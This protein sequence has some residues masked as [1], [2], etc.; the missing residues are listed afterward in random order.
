MNRCSFQAGL[1]LLLLLLTVGGKS[2]VAQNAT[3]EPLFRKLPTIGEVFDARKNAALA[4]NPPGTAG[5]TTR[6]VLE[7]GT[8]LSDS[9]AALT[10]EP[11]FFERWFVKNL[12]KRCRGVE[13]VDL[14]DD[15][16][17]RRSGE[18]VSI[19][20]SRALEIKGPKE[21]GE[22]A[23]ALVESM[24]DAKNG[25]VEVEIRFVV[26]SDDDEK[27]RTDTQVS[28]ASADEIKKL[29]LDLELR[30]AEA[31]SAPRITAYLGQR[32]V[33]AMTK[34][35]AY[36][37]D[38]DLKTAADTVIADPII[39]VIEDGL[40]INVSVIRLPGDE[41]IAVDAA[42]SMS[43]LKLPMETFETTV[44][45]G[46]PKVELQLPE[47]SYKTWKSD[48]IV[49]DPKSAGF[50]VKA[51]QYLDAKKTRKEAFIVCKISTKETDSADD[52]LVV[53]FDRDASIA[54]ARGE[55]A[56]KM[57]VGREVTIGDG[58]KISAKGRVVAV[59]GKTIEIKITEGAPK[60]DDRVR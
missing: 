59:D 16:V 31:M 48:D 42:I 11:G 43:A 14:V 15:V 28:I 51:F 4:T 37:K 26:L 54:V 12:P 19:V 23:R 40:K 20:R 24:R 49:I 44:V 10:E 27:S 5:P 6:I 3:G 7:T 18:A 38:Y 21:S 13:A 17:I 55:S 25:V 39:D 33:V 29:L 32:A 22:A 36:I 52:T 1:C 2:L 9:G 50:V 47:V 8:P 56:V 34:Q 57:T 45:E 53:A 41:G 60:R 30:K 35:T 58:D 46:A